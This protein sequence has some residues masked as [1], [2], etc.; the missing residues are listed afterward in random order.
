M[1]QRGKPF[2]RTEHHPFKTCDNF[3][4]PFCIKSIARFKIKLQLNKKQFFGDSPAPFV[5][6][7]GYP[8]V[9]VGIL[10]LPEIKEDAWL[11]DAPRFWAS[12]QFQIPQIVEYRASLINSHSKAHVKSNEKIME[13][14][15]E[16]AMAAK[17]VELEV[18]LKKQPIL[19][20]SADSV[21]APIGPSGEIKAAKITSN[22][23][24]PQK[25]EKVYS[26]KDLK[27]A[28]ALQYLYKSGFDEN[29]LSRILSV[30]VVGL[31][32]NRKLVPTKWSITASDDILGK[33][34][35]NEIKDCN[36]ID[37]CQLH[38]G[39]YLGNYFAIMLF[40]E[41]WSYELFE[42]LAG[43]Y[44]YTTDYESYEGRKKYVEETA[45]GYYAA[46]LP[47]L[48]KLKEKIRQ[49]SVLALRF[50]TEEYSIPLGVFVVR[51]AV[52][53]AMAE[54][55][56]AFASKELMIDY[57]KNIARQKFGMNIDFVL[58]ESKLL[59][60]IKQQKKLGEYL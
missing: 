33:Q 5:G 18:L 47:I 22:P 25:V 10:N 21:S 3:N 17:P 30:G 12:N 16:V 19:R 52:R 37:E 35:I 2:I 11:Y 57:I 1:M 48:E 4:C 34:L 44:D 40:P 54:K 27:A 23:K 28:E 29:F 53:K 60:N 50:I 46:R 42:M 32:T 36:Q 13:I 38:F 49:A 7:F 55:P 31:K 24:I 45:G 26:D 43:H 51:E 15:Q 58:R 59:N 9:N 39:G 14:S 56:V 20:M 41:V 6:R 8:N